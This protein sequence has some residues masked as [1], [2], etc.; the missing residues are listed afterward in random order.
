MVEFFAQRFP[1]VSDDDVI[2]AARFCF[3]AVSDL[4]LVRPRV[5]FGGD[6]YPRECLRNHWR[7]CF[8]IDEGD[9]VSTAIIR[10]CIDASSGE[11]SQL[12]WDNSKRIIGV[13][14][15]KKT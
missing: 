6:D 10:I 12:D 5:L 11:V 3:A 13:V 14:R 9:V 4:P 2:E 1:F 7:V 8:S 15:A